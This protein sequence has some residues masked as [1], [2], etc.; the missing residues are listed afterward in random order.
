MTVCINLAP[1]RLEILYRVVAL[2]LGAAPLAPCLP[3]IL[4]VWPLEAEAAALAFSDFLAAASA[5]FFS[6][7]SLM[8]WRRAAER[9][10]GRRERFSLISS[11]EAPT[12]ARWA[13]TVRRVRFLA[14]SCSDVSHPSSC[15]ASDIYQ[16][17]SCFMIS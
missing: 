7:L 12:M 2:T 13:L 16:D 10:S 11:R 6:L 14:A 9:A 5:A 8:A 1:A 17:V 3:T 15:N 4:W